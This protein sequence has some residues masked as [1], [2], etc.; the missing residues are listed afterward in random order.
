MS[1]PKPSV[2]FSQ[3]ADSQTAGSL[4]GSDEE[5]EELSPTE[6]TGADQR[7]DDHIDEQEEGEGL[8]RYREARAHE[9]FPDEVDTP[10]NMPAK[11]RYGGVCD[12]ELRFY[13]TTGMAQN[14]Q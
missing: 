1:S 2:V 11:N 3:C 4:C 12:V 8:K 13:R 7:Y 6:P 14:R 9:L 10:L 5:Q